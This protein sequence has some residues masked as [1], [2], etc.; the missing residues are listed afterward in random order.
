MLPS[1]HRTVLQE[2]QGF[3]CLTEGSEVELSI[4]AEAED[5]RTLE[6]R[7]GT[8]YTIGSGTLGDLSKVADRAL[9]DMKWLGSPDEGGGRDER[10]AAKVGQL[11]PP[12]VGNTGGSGHSFACWLLDVVVIPDSDEERETVPK[13]STKGI[14][15]VSAGRA[16]A[17]A[18]IHCYA[19]AWE[20]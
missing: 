5:G 1:P 8:P 6:E 7:R 17:V 10:E 11:V 18:G 15:R 3:G 14:L 20:C 13:R 19:D 4:R 9:G 12:E 16:A 2:G